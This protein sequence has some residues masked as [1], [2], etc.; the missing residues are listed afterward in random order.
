MS[1][2]LRWRGGL[3]VVTGALVASLLTPVAFA[4][5]ADPLGRLATQKERVSKVREVTG[6]GAKKARAKVADSKADNQAQAKRAR[7][8]QNASWPKAGEASLDLADGR[9]KAAPGGL[10]VVLTPAKDTAP[11]ATVE[12][13]SRKAAEAAG[14]SG[15]L[16]TVSGNGKAKLSLDYGEFASAYGGGW[17]GR[18]RLVE[19]PACALTT[20]EK[21]KCREQQPLKSSNDIT[22]QELSATVELDGGTGV[23]TQLMREASTAEATVLAATATSGQSASGSG[24]YTASPLT[25]SAT[26]S[27]GSSSGSFTWSYDIEVPPAAAGPAP[28]LSLSYDSGSVDGKTASTN[29]QATQ[30]GEGFSLTSSYV[31]RSYGSCDEDGHEEKYDRCWKYE[32]ASLVL[33]GKSSELV[34]DDTSGEWRLK[35]D[36]AAT[37]THSTD[38]DNADNNGEY[39]T[40]VT[41]DGTKYVFGLNKLSGAGDERTNSVWTVP[42]FGDDEGEPCYDA[43]FASA[44]CTQA[45][46]WN[47]DYV[48]DTHGN[49]MSYWYTKESNSYAKNGASTATATYTRGGYLTKILYGQRA[50]TLFTADASGKVTFDYSERCTADDCSELTDGTSDNWP[51]VPFDAICAADADCEENQ[52][53]AFFTRK[54]LTGINTYSWSASSSAYTEVDS[55]KLTQQFLDGGDIGD[56]SDQTLTLKSLTRTG[57]NGDDIALDP[58]TFTYQMRENRVDATDDILPLTRPRIETVTSETGAIT[59]VTVSE[60]ECVRG[61]HMPAAE[62]DNSL[63]CYPQYW[64]IN[65]AAEASV[66][67][68]HKYRVTAVSTAD[69]TGQNEAVYNSY[70][71][72]GPGWHYNDDPLTPSDERTWSQW[73]GYRKVTAYTGSSD[74]TQSKTVSLYLQGMDGD[75][76]SSGTRSVTEEGLELTGLTVADITDSDPY[77][78]FLREQ[79]TYDGSTPVSVTVNTPWKSKTATQHKSYADTEAYYVRTEKTSTHTYLTGT[80][81]WRTSSTETVYDDYGMAVTVQDNGDEAVDDD[82]TCART[83]YARND[84]L[85]INSLVSRSRTVGRVCSA[86]ET[87][88]SLPT[89]S[90]TRG[91]VLSDAATVYDNTSA[92]AWTASQSPTKGEVTWTGRPTAYPASAT[93]GERQPTSWQTTAKSTYDTLGRVLTGT[94][95]AGNTASTTYTPTAAGPLTRTKVTNAAG[96]SM[97]TYADPATGNPVK[98]YDVNLKKTDL[99]YDALGRLTGVWLPNRSKDAG[100]SANTTFAYSVTND[101]ASWTSTSTLKADGSSYDTTY[102]IYDALLR[103]LQVQ[104]PAATDGRLLTDTRYDTRGLVYETHADIYDTTSEPNSTYTRAEYGESPS[105][106][107]TVYDGAGRATKSTFLIGGVAQWSSTMSYTGDSTATSAVEGGSATRVLTDAQG[108]TTERREYAGTSPSGS[109][110][111]STGYTYTRDGLKK[112]VTGPD[113]EQWSY[114]YDLF[115]RQT[116]ATD[117]DTGTTATAYTALDKAETVTDARGKKLL[118][119]YDAIGRTTGVWETS[120]TDANK[121]IAYAYDGLAK[122]QLDSTTRY[123]G[124]T[125]GDAY[126]DAVVSYDSLYQV[127][128]SS[129]TLP[130]DDPLVVSGAVPSATLTFKT[131]YNVDGT[132]ASSYEPA[133]G[134][135]DDEWVSTTYGDAGLPETVSGASGYLLGASYSARGEVEQLTLGA[136]A[137]AGTPKAYVNNTWEEGTNRL[138]ESHVTT[139][140]HP[141]MLQDLK[142]GYDDAG[143]VLSIADPTTLGGTSETDNQ[144]FAYDGYRRLTEAWT[145]ATADCSTSGRTTANLDGASPYWTSYTYNDAGLRTTETDR[146]TSGTTTRTYCYDANRLHALKATTTSGNC[147]TAAEQ[148]TYND[149]GATETRPDGTATQSL[150]WN[151]EGKPATLTETGTD[152]ADGTTEYVYDADGTLLIRRN[153]QGESVL[154][155][156]ATEVHHNAATGDIWGQRSY[157]ASGSPIAV[158]SNESGTETLSFLAGDAHGTSTLAVSSTDLAVTKRYFTPFGETR[159][160]GTGT[161]P[162]DKAFLGMTADES[163]GL[164]H[165]G[166]R[167]YDPSLGRFIS[168]DPLLELEKHQSLNGYGYSENNPVTLADPSGL[169]T[170]E[171]MSGVITGCTNGVPDSDSVYHPERERTGTVSLNDASTAAY[172]NTVAAV[173]EGLPYVRNPA[174]VS[175][176]EFHKAMVKYQGSYDGA[177]HDSM[178]MMWLYGYDEEVID[179]FG[180]CLILDCSGAVTTEDV[181]NLPLNRESFL[182]M[183]GRAYAEG[184]GSRMGVGQGSKGGKGAKGGC[185]CFLAGTDVLL[186]DGT[187]KD[188]E[189]V[190]LGDE[191]QALD[192]ETGEAGPREVVRLIVTEDDKFFNELSIATEDGIE[193]LTA[194]HEHPFWSP[195]AGAWIDAGRLATGMTLLTDDGDTV[196]VTGNQAFTRHAT[197]YNLTVDDLHTYY[198]LAGETPVLVHNSSCVPLPDFNSSFSAVR[199]YSKHVLGVKGGKKGKLSAVPGGGN[200]PEFRGPGGYARYREA[201]R[202]FMSGAGPKGSISLPSTSGGMFRVDPK[203]GYFGYMNSSGTI[204]TFYRPKGDPVDYFWSQF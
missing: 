175:K 46:R 22:A 39:W 137:A 56:T 45:W 18:L 196:V 63:S 60:P 201:A 151:S 15:V 123:V 172:Y 29:N 139:T 97:Y 115:G 160:G 58:I 69:P 192:P 152:A 178:W 190:E 165:V 102:T 92:T 95:S 25:S 117:P 125:G 4:A 200:M 150:T 76:T 24:D 86:A 105:Q 168:V 187:T 141:Y 181:R 124:G 170:P 173:E 111:T 158:R 144:C 8:E 155:L 197:T 129:F 164:T 118:Y 147:L 31:E 148:Y 90:E 7:A 53:P 66:D 54:R 59:T 193:Q 16:L 184:L 19:L 88:L 126:T 82:Q 202:S 87:D 134:G 49:A 174:T 84:T 146:T 42:V 21:A 142:Y 47:L 189:D 3:V 198:V 44:S 101:A 40:V 20:P 135:L 72:S 110:Y 43:T 14:V 169:G 9:A 77:S 23:S 153:T 79:I 57:K 17:A 13:L 2:S 50:G 5:D 6:L 28:S 93:N 55:W 121:L 122:G 37:V 113:G 204:S 26:W 89:N 161:W 114:G 162:D 145:P 94:D 78:G 91:D 85:G 166:A 112:T 33:N 119:G 128:E 195:S 62:D 36:D 52:S 199:H 127:T 80:S 96:Q 100:Q 132:V 68:F 143:N 176:D 154:Y 41:G 203:T 38:G 171:C 1:T 120:K 183:F 27:A 185:K 65:G 74:L 32:N 107:E 70:T 30:V 73:R 116:S 99:T 67:W 138:T 130:S 35:D 188:I 194:T 136:S 34:K 180:P 109:T 103:R 163:T 106:T 149:I 71:Y 159:D 81:S 64:N 12:V 131:D 108:R 61:S 182:E 157:T 191:V 186:A 179:N 83:W 133:A 75:K 140:T 98:I 48:E 177:V 156:G 51:D 11:S 167:E 10:P 104:S